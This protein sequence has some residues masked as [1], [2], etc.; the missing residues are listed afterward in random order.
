MSSLEF[1]KLGR[2]IRF[3]DDK[4]KGLPLVNDWYTIHHTLIEDM[5]DSEMDTSH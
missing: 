5:G 1:I 3:G 2:V 4:C